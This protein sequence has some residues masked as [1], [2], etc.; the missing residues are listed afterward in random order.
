MVRYGDF[1]LRYFRVLLT[2]ESG[3]CV[4]CQNLSS[5]QHALHHVR[6]VSPGTVKLQSAE[7]IF[8]IGIS[9]R[10]YAG[11]ATMLERRIIYA[12]MDFVTLNFSFEF[13]TLLWAFDKQKFF[14]INVL[15]SKEVY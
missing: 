10:K 2:M 7:I 8:M 15:L 3:H 12:H 5:R 6:N 1:T 9:Y 14:Y 4:W 11:D 13:H